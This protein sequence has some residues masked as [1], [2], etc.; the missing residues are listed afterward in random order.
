MHL[1]ES[2]VDRP[3]EDTTYY[4]FDRFHAPSGWLLESFET[5]NGLSRM[6]GYKICSLLN[7][8]ESDWSKVAP[9]GYEGNASVPVPG[10]NP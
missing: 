7:F 9:G 10:V 8:A 4:G 1:W 6:F 2:M 3:H 5:V